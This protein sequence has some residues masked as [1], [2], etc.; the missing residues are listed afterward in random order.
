MSALSVGPDRVLPASSYIS[1]KPDIPVKLRIDP[2]SHPDDAVPISIPTLL[3]KA[4]ARAPDG[5]AM[6]V[7]RDG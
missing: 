7:K 5:L 1:T 4:T 3:K 6:A 2:G